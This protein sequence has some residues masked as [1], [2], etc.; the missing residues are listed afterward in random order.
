M[1]KFS[2]LAVTLL[3]FSI[4]LSACGDGGIADVT[5]F[6]GA[7]LLQNNKNTQDSFEKSLKGVKQGKLVTYAIKDDPA[8]I[9]THYENQFREKNWT[10]H[11]EAIAESSKALESQ[12]GWALAYTRGNETVSLVLTPNNSTTASLYPEATGQNI[13]TIISAAK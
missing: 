10:D 9:K 13:L 7:T 3:L 4:G 12:K 6:T 2:L 5:P 8:T 1:L 11:H